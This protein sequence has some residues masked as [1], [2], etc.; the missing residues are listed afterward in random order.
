MVH[1]I[2]AKTALAE[3]KLPASDYCLNP[4]V[5]CL[6]GCLYCY[7]RFM[8]RFTGHATE[9]WGRYVDA[10]TNMPELLVRELAGKTRKGSVLLGSV[11]DA[12][13]PI[14]ERFQ[15]TRRIIEA[16]LA[17]PDLSVSILTKSSLVTRDIDLLSRLPHVSVGLTVTSLTESVQR[18]LEP[19]ASSPSERIDALRQLHT[20][21]ISTY[22]FV[23]PIVP[24]LTEVGPIIAAVA[25]FV[26]EVWGEALNMRG[27]DKEAMSEALRDLLGEERAKHS[28]ALQRSTA[29]WD[30]TESELR[31]ASERA[32]LPEPRFFRH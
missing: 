26:D 12:Y 2:T 30:A 4:Y 8:G 32:H 15:I 19:G 3:S 27:A 17:A 21:G 1:E 10:R 31:E 23:G 20:A 6:H 25:P 24:L 7:A 14:E 11:T 9:Q 22:V 13:Q 16:L 5:G 28:S 18:R 29:Y